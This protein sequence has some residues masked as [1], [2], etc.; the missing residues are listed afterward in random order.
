LKRVSIEPHWTIR[1]DA[2]EA[3]PPRLLGLLTAVHERGS[4]AAA[5]VALGASYRHA[6]ELV[7]QG[8]ALFGAPLLHMERGRGSRLSELGEKLVWAERRIAARLAPELDSLASE[9]EAEVRRV[10][11]RGDA[12]RVHASHGFAI[13][14]L[15]RLM[16]EAGLP[17]VRRY[18][19][20]VEAVQALAEGGCEVAGFHVPVGDF[21]A[22]VL[23]RYRR[24]FDL[25]GQRVIALATRRQ[26]LMLAPGNPRKIHD[27]ADLLRPEVRFINRQPGSGTRLLLECMLRRA[28]L[29]AAAVPGFEHGEY[30]HAAVAAF[31]AS[32]MA[33]VGF[34][35]E[36]PAREFGLDFAPLATERYF[37]LL[38][39]P[40][41]DKPLLRELLRVLHGDAFREAVQ[42]LAGYAVIEPRA[43]ATLTQTFTSLRRAQRRSAGMAPGSRDGIA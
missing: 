21:E 1:L 20:S 2:T 35:L 41:L 11:D 17:V 40:T 31:V 5:S 39:A 16:A 4:L 7:R 3:L 19:G 30:T 14:T 43:P 28:G 26:G 22:E 29:D 33:D 8:E 15:L 34:G 24:W 10:L 9:L 23:E 36:T 32:G 27:L 6:W 13:E 37:L 38:D 42:R 18:L 12:L 25:R